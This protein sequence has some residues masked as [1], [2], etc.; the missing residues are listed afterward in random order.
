VHKNY[1]KLITI[2]CAFAKMGDLFFNEV[3]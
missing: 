2:H 3:E 1:N